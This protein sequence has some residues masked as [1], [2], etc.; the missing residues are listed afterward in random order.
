VEVVE[1]HPVFAGELLQYLIGQVA[2]REGAKDICND[3]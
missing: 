1:E 2:P 3:N